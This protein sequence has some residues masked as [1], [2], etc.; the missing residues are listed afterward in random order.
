MNRL[1]F[2]LSS[3][4]LA[5]GCQFDPCISSVDFNAS[6]VGTNNITIQGVPFLLSIEIC[7][8]DSN[9]CDDLEFDKVE[10]Q[11]FLEVFDSISMEYITYEEFEPESLVTAHNSEDSCNSI[12]A[13]LSIDNSGIYRPVLHLDTNNLVD[14]RDESNNII[15]G[16]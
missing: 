12:K 4:L 1:F 5:L 13:T 14:E 3:L 2:I 6:I 16:W 11:L 15:N 10:H 7:I 9:L 8:V